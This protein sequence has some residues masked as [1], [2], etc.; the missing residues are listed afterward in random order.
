VQPEPFRN[1]FD[2]ERAIC[3]LQ[4]IEH[5]GPTLSEGQCLG[6]VRTGQVTLRHGGDFLISAS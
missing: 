1:F 4:D 6:R 3:R 2:A 5:S